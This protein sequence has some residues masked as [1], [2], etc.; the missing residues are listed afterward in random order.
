[1][2]TLS[3]RV[4]RSQ[5]SGHLQQQK[6]SK[7]KGCLCRQHACWGPSLERLW[8]GPGCQVQN[9]QSPDVLGSEYGLHIRGGAG[10]GLLPELGK[11]W[12]RLE[13]LFEGLES[14]KELRASTSKTPWGWDLKSWDTKGLEAWT[15]GTLQG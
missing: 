1:M 4:G 10:P 8:W 9:P 2:A 13:D 15:P 5:K 14:P 11:S 6:Q 12:L 7:N 3:P